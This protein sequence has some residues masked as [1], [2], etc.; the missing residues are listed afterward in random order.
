MPSI[1]RMLFC[2]NCGRKT[3]HVGMVESSVLH[4]LLSVLTCGVW[5]IVWFFVAAARP[6]PECSVCATPA[7][8][9]SGAFGCLAAVFIVILIGLA[10]SIIGDCSRSKNQQSI[11]RPDHLI[12][13][14][15][16]PDWSVRVEVEP[17]P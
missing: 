15:R 7:P 2:K 13:D 8:V 11:G 6:R 14:V 4:L 1:Q 12:R 17:S 10:G 16:G 9:R 5:L 3:L